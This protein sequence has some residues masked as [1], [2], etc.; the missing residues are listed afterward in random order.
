MAIILSPGQRA[1][2]YIIDKLLRRGAFASAYK[3]SETSGRPVFLKIYK[4]PGK[5]TPWYDEYLSHEKEIKRRIVNSRVAKERCYEFIDIFEDKN[6]I[7]QVFEYV[8]NGKDL[9]EYLGEPETK[10]DHRV[11]FAKVMMYGIAGLHDIDIVHADLK[12]ENIFLIPDTEIGIGYR[13]KIIDLDASIISGR[14]APWHGDKGYI[15][16]PMYFS[17]EHIVRDKSESDKIPDKHS[18][19]FTCGIILAEIFASQHPYIKGDDYS[20][21]QYNKDIFSGN[22]KP[23]RIDKPIKGIEDLS[24]LEAIINSCMDPDPSKRPT[25]EQVCQTLAG[26]S[27]DWWTHSRSIAS[28]SDI[29]NSNNPVVIASSVEIRVD[30]QHVTTVSVDT[31]LGRSILKPYSEDARYYSNPQFKI[32]RKKG[33]WHISHC[34]TAKNQTIVNGKLLQGEVPVNDNMKVSVGNIDKKIEKFPITLFY[35]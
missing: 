9:K 22:F 3:A 28:E 18:D 13:L 21:E 34:E 7:H 4:S 12:P 10:W 1:G 15:G 27:F 14:K 17:P 31:T 33:V 24:F 20:N 29:G 19:I 16:T 5:L 8:D 35:Q 25:A 30:G 23:V 6:S 26:K 2:N 32:F 11:I